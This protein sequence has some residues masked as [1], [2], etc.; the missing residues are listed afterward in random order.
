MAVASRLEEEEARVGGVA[1]GLSE[2]GQDDVPEIDLGR[3]LV[4]DDDGDVS[5]TRDAREV[6][7]L[8]S[9]LEVSAGSTSPL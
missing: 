3:E 9:T 1:P 5:R 7:R 8:G 2:G 6:E 4:R